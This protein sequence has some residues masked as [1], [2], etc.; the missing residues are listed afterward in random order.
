MDNR[1]SKGRGKEKYLDTK[2]E[3]RI[4]RCLHVPPSPCVWHD[5]VLLYGTGDFAD[6]TEVTDQLTLK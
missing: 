2:I 1:P 3:Y 6:I 5:S 4:Q